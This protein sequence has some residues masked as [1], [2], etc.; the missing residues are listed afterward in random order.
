MKSDYEGNQVDLIKI[1]V[2]E[3][4]LAFPHCVHDDILDC[5][6]RAADPLLPLVYP[7]DALYNEKHA[8]GHSGSRLQDMDMEDFLL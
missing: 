3:E 6:A 1:F 8:A 2:E 7:E 5:L 4:Y